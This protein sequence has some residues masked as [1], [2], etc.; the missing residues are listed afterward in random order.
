MSV[1]N[2]TPEPNQAPCRHAR[3]FMLRRPRGTD[4]V[5]LSV[6]TGMREHKYMVRNDILRRS[7][8]RQVNVLGFC[9]CRNLVLLIL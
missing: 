2:Q 9:S 7:S 3:A 4:G 6:C 1:T 8:N 5:L